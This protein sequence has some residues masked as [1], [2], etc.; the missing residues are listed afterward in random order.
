MR[1]YVY[2]PES[3]TV[4]ATGICKIMHKQVYVSYSSFWLTGPDR[5]SHYSFVAHI[6]APEARGAPIIGFH[7]RSAITRV[8]AVVGNV[9]IPTIDVAATCGQSVSNIGQLA[10]RRQ[11]LRLALSTMSASTSRNLLRSIPQ[12]ATRDRARLDWDRLDLKVTVEE[13]F[14]WREATRRR[15][16]S[17][18][19]GG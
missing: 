12:T 19:Q 5:A 3:A 4:A 10:A 15:N 9:S 7:L 18:Q 11:P 13:L 17:V 6:T 1:L 14:A 8:P 16:S 2:F